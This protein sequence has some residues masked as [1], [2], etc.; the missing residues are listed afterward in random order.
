MVRRASTCGTFATSGGSLGNENITMALVDQPVQFDTR[1]GRPCNQPRCLAELCRHDSIYR[2]DSRSCSHSTTKP[3]KEKGI[4]TCHQWDCGR[5]DL[6]IWNPRLDVRHRLS[7]W[8]CRS[9][10]D[11]GEGVRDGQGVRDRKWA[12][13]RKGA[14]HRYGYVFDRRGAG[15]GQR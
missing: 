12:E 15:V 10:D 9:F 4:P 1:I 14:D 3:E 5:R 7:I 2:Q 8:R 11:D 13:D 6:G